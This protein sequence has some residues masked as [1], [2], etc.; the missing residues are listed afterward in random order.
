MRARSGGKQILNGDIDIATS[1]S[2][3]VL[4]KFEESIGITLNW[5]TLDSK[6]SIVVC[7][8]NARFNWSLLSGYIG[9]VDSAVLL[10]NV[11]VI[12]NLCFFVEG[13]GAEDY[14]HVLPPP[15]TLPTNYEQ[16]SP[17]LNY[18]HDQPVQ[19]DSL[20]TQ[21]SNTDHLHQTEM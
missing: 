4:K 18:E 10:Q 17:D 1:I 5:L 6:R 16:S 2:I 12:I 20:D 9:S 13:T 21:D 15:P 3:T 19:Q 11:I 8:F 14:T 7:L